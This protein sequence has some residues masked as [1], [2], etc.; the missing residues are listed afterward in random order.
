MAPVYQRFDLLLTAGAAGPAPRLDAHKSVTFWQRPNLTTPFNVT[1]G[2]ALSVCCG[3]SESGLPLAMQLAGRPFEDA[4]V[5]R[6]GHAYEQATDW[7][8]RRPELTAGPKPVEPLPQLAVPEITLD[9]ATRAHVEACADAA[10][11]TLDETQFA[12]LCEGAPYALAMAQRLHTH[13]HAWPRE[14]A[15]VFALPDR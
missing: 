4:T 3:F 8:S 14:P 13:H 5:L 2:P 1:G 10:G 11:L 15:S 9:G 12:L 7:R 6:A